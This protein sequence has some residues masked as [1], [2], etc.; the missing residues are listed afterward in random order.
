M[1]G[2]LIQ[3]QIKLLD[4]LIKDYSFVAMYDDDIEVKV[5]DRERAFSIAERERLDLFAPA[6]THDSHYTYDFTLYEGRGVR[7]V[8]WVE[9]MMP[10]FS[11]RFLDR[12]KC[13]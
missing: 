10:H 6:L 12:F 4:D 5:S 13:H 1:Q 2:D 9:I 11:R 8:E 3:R 7:Q